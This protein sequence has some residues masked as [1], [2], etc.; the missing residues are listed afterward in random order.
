MRILLGVLLM[1]A[2][3]AWWLLAMFASGMTTTGS[4]AE[5]ERAAWS[6]LCLGVVLGLLVMVLPEW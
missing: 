3:A 4:D 5:A 2:G 6:G 1:V